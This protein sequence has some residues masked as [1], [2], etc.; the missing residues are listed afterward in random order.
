MYWA[1][2][3]TVSKPCDKYITLISSSDN[4]HE[5]GSC[6]VLYCSWLDGYDRI[7]QV[8]LLKKNDDK[9]KLTKVVK[10]M[11]VYGYLMGFIFHCISNIQPNAQAQ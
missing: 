7:S 11:R 4:G 1:I 2:S 3:C 8:L 10:F 9:L 6:F 5:V